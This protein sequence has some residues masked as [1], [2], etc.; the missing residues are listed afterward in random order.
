MERFTNLLHGQKFNFVGV[1][2]KGL[3]IF[4]QALV[5]ARLLRE[6]VGRLIA[7]IGEMFHQNPLK[8][9][10]LMPHGH[11]KMKVET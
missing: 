4:R 6:P 2:A 7:S 10:N 5:D 1:K 11:M 8:R 9:G 3:K